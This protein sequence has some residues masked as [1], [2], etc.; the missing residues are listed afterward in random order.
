MKNVRKNIPAMALLALAMSALMPQKA[1][2][3]DRIP[4]L[5][6][7]KT[8]TVFNYD[9]RYGYE[10]ALV[11]KDSARYSVLGDTIVGGR[12][13]KLVETEIGT[14]P[15]YQEGR[16][17]CFYYPGDAEPRIM[18]EFDCQV[19]D[20]VHVDSEREARAEVTKVDSVCVEGAYYRVVHYSVDGMEGRYNELIGSVTGVLN[21]ILL[22]GQFRGVEVTFRGKNLSEACSIEHSE[23]AST[24]DRLASDNRVYTL[25]GVRLQQP[26]KQGV[27]IQNGKKFVAK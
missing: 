13:C 17:I 9:A 24:S 21:A 23:K 26:P 12:T 20:L 2:A 18:Y 5:A 6:E 15:A 19:G 16:N 25:Q 22:P 11:V 3:Q 10:G 8:W 4:F 27:Y 14:V 7:G 1:Q